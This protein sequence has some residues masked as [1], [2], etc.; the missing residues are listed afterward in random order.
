VVFLI[1]A[2]IKIMFS[3]TASK[4]SGHGILRQNGS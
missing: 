2:G 3:I 4:G 1:H